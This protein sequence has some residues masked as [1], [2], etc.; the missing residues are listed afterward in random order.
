[1]QDQQPFDLRDRIAIVTGASGGFGAE[2]ARALAG[3]R[4]RT[5]AR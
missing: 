2:S 1:M 4:A 3:A 5:N